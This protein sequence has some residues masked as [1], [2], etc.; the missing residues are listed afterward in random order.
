MAAEAVSPDVTVPMESVLDGPV[1]PFY[2]L[3]STRLSAWLGASPV[4]VAE[5]VS[6]EETV[7]IESVLAG[8]VA[9]VYPLGPCRPSRPQAK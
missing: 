2:P 7:P 1:S 8:P 6:P 5:A 3:G 4:I 9:P